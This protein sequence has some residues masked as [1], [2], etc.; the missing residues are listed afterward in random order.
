MTANQRRWAFTPD[1]FAWVWGETGSDEYPDP[2]SIIETATTEDEY[3]LQIGE[4][5]ARYPRG[6]APELTAALRILAAP[7]VRIIGTGYSHHFPEK[8]FRAVAAATGDT[9]AVLVQRSGST[10]QAGADVQLLITTRHNLAR[11]IAAAMPVNTA[12]PAEKMAGYTPRVRGEQ[13]PTTWFHDS[14]GRAPVEERMRAFLRA[15]RAAEGHF[16]IETHVVRRIPPEYL[17][18]VDLREDRPA[19]GRYLVAVDEN[20]TTIAPASKEV[21]ERQLGNLARLP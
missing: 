13:Q 3:R 2:V 21:I 6:S 19:A 10:P 16:T 20:N 1:E 15:P 14:A 5:S 12:G 9:G 8:R 4:I 18:W 11:H 17:S 7:E